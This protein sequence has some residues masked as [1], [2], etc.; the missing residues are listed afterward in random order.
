EDSEADGLQGEFEDEPEPGVMPDLRGLSLREASRAIAFCACEL[1]VQGEGYVVAQTPPAGESV[2]G[3][4]RV[5]LVLA[6]SL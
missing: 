3:D 5:S 6:R 2:G 1:D 4:R